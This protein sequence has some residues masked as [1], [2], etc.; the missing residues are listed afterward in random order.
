MAHAQ[1]SASGIGAPGA[2]AGGLGTAA[3]HPAGEQQASHAT[4][5]TRRAGSAKQ[6][7]TAGSGDADAGNGAAARDMPDGRGDDVTAARLRR[8]AQTE[9]DPA[10]RRRLWQDYLDYR[11]N[12][13]HGR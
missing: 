13:L 11:D 8:A 9:T 5:H 7:G 10:V 12:V 2:K 3:P 1:A 6:G 4:S